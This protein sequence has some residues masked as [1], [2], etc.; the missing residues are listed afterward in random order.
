MK[1]GR[2]AS[3]SAF[4]PPPFLPQWQVPSEVT[5][6]CL[7]LCDTMDCSPPGSSVQGI[8]QARQLEWV[9][10]PSSRGSSIH[11][12]K[13]RSPT[14]PA[15]SLLLVPFE[16][17]AKNYY[18]IYK[19]N[20]KLL[21]PAQYFFTSLYLKYLKF[22]IIVGQFTTQVSTHMA[23]IH[24]F[25]PGSLVMPPPSLLILVICLLCYS[26]DQTGQVYFLS[27]VVARKVQN[28]LLPFSPLNEQRNSGIV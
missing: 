15:N 28:V 3:P 9:A 10:M 22:I 18:Q 16:R 21:T 2:E 17:L 7:T 12:I 27:Q 11:G 20:I 23:Q 5:Q 6:S 25:V 13:P 1:Q 26:P 8:L 4:P 24:V 19:S 14:S